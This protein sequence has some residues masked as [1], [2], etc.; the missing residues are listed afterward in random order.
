MIDILSIGLTIGAAISG[1]IQFF[2]ITYPGASLTWWGNTFYVSG[3]DGLGCPLKEMPEVGYFGPG[4][5]QIRFDMHSL[6][7]S[8][9]SA[10][11][12]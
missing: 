10:R 7:S 9:M 1:V 5:S 12:I 8:D 11:R 2:C 3:C 4:V 6:I